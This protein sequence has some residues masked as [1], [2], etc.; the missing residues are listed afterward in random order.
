MMGSLKQLKQRAYAFSRPEQ[1]R[2][3]TKEYRVVLKNLPQKSDEKCACRDAK[4][5]AGPDGAE[6]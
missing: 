3:P 6:K 5:N 2:E 4:L 1:K